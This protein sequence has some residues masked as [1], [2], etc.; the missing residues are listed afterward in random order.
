MT[1][2]GGRW[3]WRGFTGLSEPGYNGGGAGVEAV[4]G[5]SWGRTDW[6]VWR[7]LVR[8][9]PL[10]VGDLPAGVAIPARESLSQRGFGELGSSLFPARNGFASRAPSSPRVRGLE[11]QRVRG[12]EG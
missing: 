9:R 2:E 7:F 6:S 8:L 1:P 5:A 12:L 3:G 10:L 4:S 11:G